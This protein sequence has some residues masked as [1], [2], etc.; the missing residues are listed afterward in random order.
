MSCKIQ[1]MRNLAGNTVRTANTLAVSSAFLCFGC[2]MKFNLFCKPVVLD[3]QQF[4]TE[5]KVAAWYTKCHFFQ[6]EFFEG[7]F[8]IMTFPLGEF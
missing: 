3:K 1:V 2:Q 6:V 7:L 5:W 8:I 4:L